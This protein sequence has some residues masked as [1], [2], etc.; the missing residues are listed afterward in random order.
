M[1]RSGFFS[2]DAAPAERHIKT[3]ED[4]QSKVKA[5]RVLGGKIAL[6]SGSYDLKHIGHERYL[7]EARLLADF[8]I[9]G[10]ESD[11]RIQ[12]R[13]G[14]NR[15][16]VPE[17]ERVEA[18]THLRYVDFVVTKHVD[19]QPRQ[20]I[21]MVCPDVL[22]IS[23]RTAYDSDEQKELQKLCGKIV[24]LESQAETS[25]SARLRQLQ[26]E[27][28]DPAVTTL[29]EALGQLKKLQGAA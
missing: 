14:A 8:L 10:V 15:P 18:L 13:K 20:L 26:L 9:V 2:L 11:A 12:K 6:T 27:A 16:I 3:H 22:V 1:E 5:V 17:V 23:K 29:E 24:E 7:R 21:K 28:L 19:D 25:T 4:L